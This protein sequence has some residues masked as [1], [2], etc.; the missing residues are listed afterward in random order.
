MTLTEPKWN[1]AVI[2]GTGK[3]GRGLAARWA[4]AGQSIIIGSRQLDKAR[5]VAAELES[6]LGTRVQ[7]LANRDAAAAGDVVVFS[8][9]YVAQR[10]ILADIRGGCQGKVLINVGVPLDPDDPRRIQVLPAGSATAEAQALL[11]D[12]VKVVAAFQNI[13]AVKLKDPHAMVDCDVLVCGDDLE[14]KALA[15]RLAELAGMRPLDAGPLVNAVGVET[16]TAIL[17][18]INIRHKAKGAGIRVTG[19]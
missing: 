1:I 14:A 2:G 15:M 13:S 7:G 16:L 4:L 17:I 6:Q 10:D 18:G 3:E 8:V 19:L 11:G 9:P 12:G 5:R